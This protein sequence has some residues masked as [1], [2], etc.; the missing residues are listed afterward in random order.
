MT[1]KCRFNENIKKEKLSALPSRQS[2]WI[3]RA[4]QIKFKKLELI[5]AIVK[6]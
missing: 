1:L 4:M 6:S 3:I 5:W 2:K